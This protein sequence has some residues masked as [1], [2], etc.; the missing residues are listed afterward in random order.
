MSEADNEK[1]KEEKKKSLIELI[2]DFSLKVLRYRG[3]IDGS[4][5]SSRK[6]TKKGDE[7]PDTGCVLIWA[8]NDLRCENGRRVNIAK[9]KWRCPVYKNGNIEYVIKE[10]E[11]IL[12]VTDDPC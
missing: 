11:D 8:G 2:I 1:S 4:Y 3:V 7:P 10:T 12:K 6:N 9:Y 5:E